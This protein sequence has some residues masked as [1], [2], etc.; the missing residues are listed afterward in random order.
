MDKLA[1][2]A[3]VFFVQR[4]IDKD[5]FTELE[6]LV[7]EAMDFNISGDEKK[8]HVLVALRSLG[9]VIS[10]AVAATAGWLLNL[11]LEAVVAKYK[12]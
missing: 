12:A 11:A 8:E 2:N 9:S 4:L 6:A 3:I 5:V 10:P 1:I 7:R